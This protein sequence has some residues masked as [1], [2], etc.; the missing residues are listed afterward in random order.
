MT[1]AVLSPTPGRSCRRP[2]SARNRSSASS[3]RAIS[4]AARR[5]AC[6]AVDGR[7]AAHQQL[8][9]ALEGLDRRHVRPYP[10][11]PWASTA[12][13]CSPLI[14]VLLGNKRVREGA[15]GGVRGARTATSSRSV[16]GRGSTCRSCPPEVTGV[17]TVEP[18][19]VACAARGEAHRRDAGRRARGGLD[20]AAPRLPRRSV[21]QRA[22]DDDAVH[23]PRRRRV[24]ARVA[25][26]A[27]AGRRRSTSPSTVTRPTAR[28]RARRI[29]STACSR[30]I[31]GGCNLNRAIDR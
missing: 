4:R 7:A 18:S 16:S 6:C 14:D 24:A 19:R 31:A 22:L 2:L 15:P 9:D 28:S 27:E 20:G 13:R 29:G 30:T 1:A 11:A 12:S 3:T 5:N 17:W 23:D 26:R 25:P 8:G 21:R 10:L